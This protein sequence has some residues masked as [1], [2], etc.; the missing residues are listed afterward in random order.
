MSL[1][2][3]F[4]DQTGFTLIEVVVATGIVIGVLVGISVG[5]A[6]AVRNSRFSQEKIASLRLAQESVE[7]FRQ[8]RDY[9]GWPA[10]S[11]AI[12]EHVEQPSITFCLP[13]RPQAN[14]EDVEF[15]EADGQHTGCYVQDSSYPPNFYQRRITLTPN[16]DDSL[17][18]LELV[19][20]V[21]WTDGSDTHQTTVNYQLY[22]WR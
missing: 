6:F 8:Q 21:T 16:F 7:W 9:Y 17:E 14:L 15:V 22:K 1:K 11:E 10:F 20:T 2:K 12:E 19:S 13:E 3:I 5:V 4:K 18:N